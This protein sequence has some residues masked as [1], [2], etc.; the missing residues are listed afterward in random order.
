MRHGIC[1]P[2]HGGAPAFEAEPRMEKRDKAL[3][4]RRTV[5]S[6]AVLLTALSIAVAG[7]LVIL[8]T[9]LHDASAVL[10]DTLREVRLARQ[11]QVDLLLRERAENAAERAALD[12]RLYGALHEA[13][14]KIMSS[15]STQRQREEAKAAVAHYLDET[16]GAAF[17]E[18]SRGEANQDLRTALS[19]IDA[20]VHA[21]VEDAERARAGADRLDELG[22]VIGVVAILLMLGVPA[23]LLWWMRSSVARPIIA[24]S[25]AMDRFGKGNLGVRA[26]PS[27][28]TELRRMAG[29][30][31]AMGDALLRQHQA[32]LAHLAG[33]A[34]D[35]RN[36][37]AALQMSAVVVDASNAPMD[38][39]TSRA[40]GIVR[41]QV[42]RLTRMV[43][44]LLDATRIEAGQLSLVLERTDL[45][46]VVRATIELFG[47]TSASH[48]IIADLPKEPV[49]VECDPLRIE[50]TLNNL[51][52]N[53]IKY[54]PRGGKIRVVV[55]R[56]GSSAGVSVTDSGIGIGELDLPYIWEPFRR[57][58]VS[59]E[60]VPGVG[61]GLW[62]SKKIVDAHGGTLSVE[63]EVE[64]GSTFILTLPVSDAPPEHSVEAGHGDPVL[65]HG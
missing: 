59:T 28:A 33:V 63:S 56:D 35:L 38:E 12:E 55:F 8:T 31:N 20:L 50:Q 60:T 30:F 36:P 10:R 16:R 39:G 7:S 23:G 57:T 44:D 61:L 40:F 47:N 49:Y 25:D 21:N 26:T 22:D 11:V 41:R 1:V 52:S 54:S 6:A 64:R 18:R 48:A 5:T 43:D 65:S 32:R 14:E 2:L 58:G 62:T 4:L 46:G 24:L 53:A 13:D 3:G 9:R 19:S 34:H 15:A 45:R 27:G 17:G 29:Q 51:L 37:L 42:G